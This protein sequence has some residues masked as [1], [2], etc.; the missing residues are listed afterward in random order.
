MGLGFC[1]EGDIDLF[2]LNKDLHLCTRSLS[3]K[4][5][6]NKNTPESKESLII[7]N[8]TKGDFRSLGDLT[9]LAKES[10][11]VKESISSVETLDLRNEIDLNYLSMP[12]TKLFDTTKPKLRNKSQTF[13]SINLNPN[14][15][16]F[17][18]Q[19]SKEFQK[20]GSNKKTMRNLTKKQVKALKDLELYDHFIIKP[21]DKGGNVVVMDKNFYENV[22]EIFTEP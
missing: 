20:L 3:L 21:S 1:I 17:H 2:K 10:T 18:K 11:Q 15:S 7:E 13:S 4:V 8:M 5:L 6:H 22:F 19:V 16:L 14:I 9:L 12:N